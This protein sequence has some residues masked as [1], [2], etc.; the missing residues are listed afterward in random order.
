VKT[1]A[2]FAAAALVLLLDAVASVR[3]G[4]SEVLSRAQKTA[5]LLAVWLAPVIGAI[6]ALHVSREASIPAPVQG[7]LEEI[8]NPGIEPTKTGFL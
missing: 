2:F 3:V 6:L 1:A 4:G 8:P 5:W 7:L